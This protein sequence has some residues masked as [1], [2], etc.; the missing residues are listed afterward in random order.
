MTPK[1]PVFL[2]TFA[3]DAQGSLR[4]GEEMNAC[5]NELAALDQAG[6]LDCQRLGFASL[7][8]VYQELNRFRDQVFLLHYGGHSDSDFLELQGAE[9]SAKNLGEKIGQ[10]SFLKLAFLN[11]CRNY[12]QVET[13]LDHGVPVVIATTALIEDQRA[14]ALARQFYQALANGHS[15]GEAF[16]SARTYLL[17]KYPPLG[18]TFRDAGFVIPAGASV[19]FE[20]GIYTRTEAAL[21]WSIREMARDAPFLHQQLREASRERHRTF[22]GPGGRFQHLRIEEAILSG[23]AD[24]HHAGR[25]LIEEEITLEDQSY[26][27]ERVLPRLWAKDCPHAVITGAGGMGKTVSLLRLWEYWAGTDDANSPVPIFIQ[28]NE[29]NNQ[30][31]KDFIRRYIRRHYGDVDLDVLLKAS[32]GAAEGPQLIL[33]L[34]GFNE[35]TATNTELLLEINRLKARE[36]Y[37]GVQL[38]LSSRTDMRNTFQWQAFQLLELRPLED[39]RIKAYLGEDLPDNARLLE[40]LRN[41]MMLSLHAAQSGLPARYHAKGLL[42]TEVTSTGELLYNVEAIQRIKIE[43]HYATSTADQAYHRFIL[44]HLLPF[45]GWEMQQLGVFFLARKGQPDEA[46]GLPDILRRGLEYLLTDDFFDTFEFF[47]DHLE[48]DRFP[49]NARRLFASVVQ[50][51]MIQ[52]LAILSRDGENYRFLHQHYRDYFA[53]RHVQNEIAKSLATGRLPVVLKAAPLDYYVRHLLGELEGEHRSQMEWRAGEKRWQWSQGRFFL[54]NHLARLLDRCRGIYG[55]DQLGYTIWNLLTIWKEQRGELSGGDW[56]RL[57]FQE[58]SFNGL[59]VARPGLVASFSGGQGQQENWFARG[60]A[61]SVNSVAYSPDGRCIITGS[62]DDTAKVW[63]A[64]TGA[65]LLTLMGHSQMVLSVAYSPDGRHIITGSW[66]TTAKVWDA[67]SGDC[68]LTIKGHQDGV[69]STAEN[70]R[71]RKMSRCRWAQK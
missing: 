35:V 52:E 9:G 40:L 7:E 5:W 46:P 70:R 29:F 51:V 3:N 17:D 6:T 45:V 30:P 25:P 1:Q 2:L 12:G 67:R 15:I 66:D 57:R 55:Q 21:D 36:D 62:D 19:D 48:E 68:L 43:D 32:S 39:A 14:V 47:S 27:L 34:D 56:S 26:G 42:K 22:T 37:P 44:E 59:R 53:A 50:Q 10:Q 49:D 71:G 23:I 41:P 65:C 64:Q 69:T 61:G 24:H 8:Q 4:L 13:L 63:D 18:A 16:A 33:L 11:G 38:I 31:E 60:H 54:D 28:L 20:W 58:F